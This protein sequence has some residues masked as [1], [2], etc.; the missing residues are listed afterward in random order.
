MW[1]RVVLWSFTFLSCALLFLLFSYLLLG[2]IFF[3]WWVFIR[4]SQVHCGGLPFLWPFFN[5]LVDVLLLHTI[6]SIMPIYIF[7]PVRLDIN[8]V[9]VHNKSDS[10]D[11]HICNLLCYL[12][13]ICNHRAKLLIVS[14]EHYVVYALFFQIHGSP[15]VRIENP[16]T[17]TLHCE[18]LTMLRLLPHHECH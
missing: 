5:N 1:L 12:G 2:F 7:D 17:V 8:H 15:E 13:L 16:S 11:I 6:C 9:H 4:I 10:L 3:L 14:V 18:E